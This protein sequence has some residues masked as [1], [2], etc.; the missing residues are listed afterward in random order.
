[1]ERQ[2]SQSPYHWL[3]MISLWGSRDRKHDRQFRSPEVKN[4]V[5]RLRQRIAKADDK[6]A[7]GDDLEIVRAWEK[8]LWLDHL[9]LV[10]EKERILIG[11]ILWS[12]GQ[13]PWPTIPGH[14]PE[15][16]WR[17]PAPPVIEADALF[18]K[19]LLQKTLADMSSPASMT[20]TNS[21]ARRSWGF[22]V[23]D[24][25]LRA[26]IN[27][28]VREPWPVGEVA[29]GLE[30][31]R[32]WWEG[33]WSDLAHDAPMIEEVHA[34]L[35]DRLDKLDSIFFKGLPSNWRTHPE[36]EPHLAVWVDEV[37]AAGKQA[38]APFWRYRLLNA[39]HKADDA[40]LVA[41]QTELAECLLDTARSEM[42]DNAAIV[43]ADW[44]RLENSHKPEILIEVFGGIIAARRMPNLIWVLHVLEKM[45]HHRADWIDDQLLSMIELGLVKLE[46]ELSYR[47]RPWGT[48]IADEE[49]P[50]LRFNCARLAI[51]LEW[52]PNRLSSAATSAWLS[53][54]ANDPLPEMRFLTEGFESNRAI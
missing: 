49:V 30:I 23:N 9:G 50:I 36:I 34:A 52:S 7:R 32:R 6:A 4:Q 31:V 47:D 48:A 22:P 45:V 38:G 21:K 40:T 53:I 26:W 11:K 39:L 13:E 46:A 42:G 5:E 33:E 27:S 1:M 12:R 15:A 43:S 28:L 20:T 37:V 17:W 24:A 2:Q 14:F 35:I 25:F 3:N 16:T 51:A 19:M 18:R 10:P 29:A 44:I 54:A 8:L 41:I